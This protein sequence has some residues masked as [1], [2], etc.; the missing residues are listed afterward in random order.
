VASLERDAVGWTVRVAS[1][2]VV[3]DAVVLATPAF[4]SARLLRSVST[5]ASRELEGIPYASTALVSFVYPRG[6]AGTLPPGTGFIVPGGPEAPAL[7]ACTWVSSKW[8]LEEHD[9]RAVIR[10]YVGRH[11]DQAA[12]ELPDDE[13]I[14]RITEE[15]ERITPLGARPDAARVVRWPRSMP[16][17]E[18]GHLD[19]L[20]R[21]ESALG[22]SSGVFLAGSAYRGVGIADC[23]RQGREVAERVRLHL[24]PA[25]PGGSTSNDAG[26][27]RGVEQEAT[28]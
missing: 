23:V 16:Q 3:A 25:R 10:C 14:A 22:T 11:G 21:I 7:T 9:G 2:P 1:E 13:L 4:E 19:R 5:E 26:T 27:E 17:Y 12:L 6:T 28:T 18:V 15:V 20:A 8:P 24:A